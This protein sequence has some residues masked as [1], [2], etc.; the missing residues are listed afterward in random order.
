M[1]NIQLAALFI[2]GWTLIGLICF[3]CGRL[4]RA[5]AR[6]DEIEAAY[7]EGFIAG[8]QESQEDL[9]EALTKE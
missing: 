9:R 2:L 3:A 5:G 4:L 8:K 1:T 6:A 7:M